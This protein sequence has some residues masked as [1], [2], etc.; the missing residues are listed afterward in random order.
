MSHFSK[1]KTN[2]KDLELLKISL[3]DL[4]IVFDD[5]SEI[6]EGTEK[7][8]IDLVIKQPNKYDIGFSWNGNEYQLITDIQ[9][10]QQ[11]C[12]IDMFLNR[13]TQRYAYNSINK[14]C[15]SKGFQMVEEL[16]QANGS[17]KLTLQRW[18]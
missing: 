10:W 16:K 6:I 7:Q 15:E 18:K 11:S 4:G 8:Y 1:I 3:S 12:P 13:L 14:T 9:F 2:L 17:V 5:T